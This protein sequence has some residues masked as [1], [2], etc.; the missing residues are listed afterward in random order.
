MNNC[1]QRLIT[2][3]TPEPPK[4]RINFTTLDPIPRGG[5]LFVMTTTRP[6]PAHTKIAI[7]CDGTIDHAE[8]RTVGQGMSGKAVILDGGHTVFLEVG[9][10]FW[11]EEMPLIVIGH[12]ST[13]LGTCAMRVL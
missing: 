4:F 11:S 12:L 13:E 10:A 9:A 5:D 8:W 3:S 7:T 2:L 1:V 6:M